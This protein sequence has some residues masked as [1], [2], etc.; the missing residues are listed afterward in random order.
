MGKSTGSQGERDVDFEVDKMCVRERVHA[1]T[2][3]A[4]SLLVYLVRGTFRTL[5]RLNEM[6]LCVTFICTLGE[7]LLFMP[8][9]SGPSVL[10]SISVCVCVR[11]R[12]R[13]KE[14]DR[15]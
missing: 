5:R 7:A 14:S 6:P 2:H 1:Y 4:R 3:T 12:K 9:N 15:M 8:V 13:E 11:E 10:H